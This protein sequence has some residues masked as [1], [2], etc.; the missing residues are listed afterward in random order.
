MADFGCPQKATPPFVVMMG[1]GK[2]LKGYGGTNEG[3]IVGLSNEFNFL[4]KA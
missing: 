2:K 4:N 3:F 1:S